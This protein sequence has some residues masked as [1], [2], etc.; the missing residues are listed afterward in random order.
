MKLGELLKLQTG[1]ADSGLDANVQLLSLVEAFLQLAS[2]Q[3]AAAVTLPVNVLGLAG[4][5]TRVK[6]V[7]SRVRHRQ[8]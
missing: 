4:V 8:P 1:T 7:T 3:S 6:I 2:S 5:T